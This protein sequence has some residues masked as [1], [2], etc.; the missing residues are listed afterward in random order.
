MVE[1]WLKRVWSG[2]SV[3]ILDFD[4][5]M[6]LKQTML[7]F[8]NWNLYLTMSNLLNLLAYLLKGDRK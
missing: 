3:Y 4:F 5:P 8:I 2:Y 7:S 1:S 6:S